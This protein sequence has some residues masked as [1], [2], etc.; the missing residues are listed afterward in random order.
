MART[1]LPSYRVSSSL[2]ISRFL[3]SSTISLSGLQCSLCNNVV[4][5]PVQTPCRKLVCT[6]CVV[7]LL[8]SCNQDNYP[9][10]SCHESHP[11]DQAAFPEA[12]TAVMNMLGDLLIKCDGADC[13]QVV[14]LKNL[15]RHLASGCSDR[16]PTFSP[17]KL[18]VAQLVLSHHR[19]L[20]QRGRL[21][22]T[23]SKDY[24][25]H[26]TIVHPWW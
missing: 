25:T 11:V 6:M 18:T 8:Q 22:L 16:A 15:R 4:D 21:Q 23:W 17:S 9:C 26:H 5:Q 12:T 1:E 2:S 13:T 7:H 14:S 19:Q 3:P 24:C 10:P 20:L